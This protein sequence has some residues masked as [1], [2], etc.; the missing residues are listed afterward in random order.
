MRSL[1]TTLA[2]TSLAASH[3]VAART[4]SPD[5][6]P[7]FEKG[8]A[9]YAEQAWN[10]NYTECILAIASSPFNGTLNVEVIYADGTRNDV[11]TS[12]E[13][14]RS[15]KQAETPQPG[16]K[17]NG[18][19]YVTQNS[20]VWWGVEGVSAKGIGTVAFSYSDSNNTDIGGIYNATD[21]CHSLLEDDDMAEGVFAV[22]CPFRC[23]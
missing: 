7:I 2:L 5:L 19:V 3:F 15:G 9:L 10:N 6:D 23:Y 21:N 11:P 12:G 22:R 4:A 16:F 1:T 8:A 14:P 17:T 18:Y 20:T 13:L